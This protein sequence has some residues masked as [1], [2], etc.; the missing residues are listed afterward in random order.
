LGIL[1]AR[2]SSIHLGSRGVNGYAK[3]VASEAI[4]RSSPANLPLAKDERKLLELAAKKA[5]L[6][7]GT[8]MRENCLARGEAG[9]GRG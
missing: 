3:T 1:E 8:S 7:L 2:W 5:H 4:A 9:G 6:Q